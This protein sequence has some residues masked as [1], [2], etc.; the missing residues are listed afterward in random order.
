MDSPDSPAN[1]AAPP[2]ARRPPGRDGLMMDTPP[3]MMWA[4]NVGAIV[5]VVGAIFMAVQITHRLRT[6]VIPKPFP[7]L[8][9]LADSLRRAAPAIVQ[10]TAGERERAAKALARP[11]RQTIGGPAP[12]DSFLRAGQLALGQGRLGEARRAFAAAERDTTNASVALGSSLLA[13]WRWCQALSLPKAG[14]KT[15]VV[16]VASTTWSWRR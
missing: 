15:S 3:W 11:V 14:R 5:A 10:D 16:P 6:R 13:S 8:A 7:S 2:P 9:H 1:P 12:T 4:S